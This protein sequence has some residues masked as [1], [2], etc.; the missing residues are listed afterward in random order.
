MYLSIFVLGVIGSQLH[1]RRFK[2]WRWE[3]LIYRY[4]DENHPGMPWTDIAEDQQ[5]W[6]RLYIIFFDGS[7]TQLFISAVET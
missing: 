6:I 2:V 7:I 1:G 3:A 4:F 5:E